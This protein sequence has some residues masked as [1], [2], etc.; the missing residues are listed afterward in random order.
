MM[1]E[2]P[3][4]A[5][6][7]LRLQT[8]EQFLAICMLLGI[9]LAVLLNRFSMKGR[10][11]FMPFTLPTIVAIGFVVRLPMFSLGMWYD[12]TFSSVMTLSSWGDMLTAITG[13]VHPPLYYAIQKCFTLILGHNDITLRLPAFISGL[14]FIVVVYHIAKQWG[15]SGVGRWA[16]FIVALLPA[17]VFYSV[18]ARYPMFLALML[19]LAYIG[20]QQRDNRLISIPLSVAA[21]TH[22]NAWVYVAVMLGL[23]IL[24]TR[25]I[26]AAVLPSLTIMLWLPIAITQSQDVLDGFWLDRYH[27]YRHLLEMSIGA[28][29]TGIESAFLPMTITSMIT[30]VALWQGRRRVSWLWLVVVALVP[31]LQWIPGI[32]IAPVYLPRTLLL[33]TVLLI[34]PVSY[35]LA[36]HANRIAAALG[37]VALMVGLWNQYTIPKQ[38]FTNEA[39]AMCDGFSTI[40]AT[41]THTAILAKHY[42]KQ[43]HIRVYEG[44]NSIAQQL[45]LDAR[46]AL[47]DS[48]GTLNTIQIT[49]GGINTIQLNDLCIISQI[50]RYNTRN[51]LQHLETIISSHNPHVIT[52]GRDES[53]FVYYLVM[54]FEGTT[55]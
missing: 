34:L 10:G 20:I 12:E 29:F 23:Y 48:V 30:A 44:G 31:I 17:T 3:S 35:W 42:H 7:M 19:G 26:R 40:Y 33:S 24:Q 18:E 21:L 14:A 9:L 13:D 25:R 32:V 51:E 22:V 36:N 38:G 6:Y 8:Y 2:Q 16:S 5:T 27:I 53:E 50:D 37:F 15:G 54:T 28:R 46:A 47:F 52:V 55:Q 49:E 11:V 4:A 45:T 43:S 39:M 41:N 1:I